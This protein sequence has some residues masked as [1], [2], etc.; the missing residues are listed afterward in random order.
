MNKL[1]Y[2]NPLLPFSSIAIVPSQVPLTTNSLP[3]GNTTAI[4][5]TNLPV[6]WL[7][8]VFFNAF[9]NLFYVAGAAFL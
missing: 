5:Q 1:S 8:A 4:Q 6:L 9:N 7:A 3:S 2:P